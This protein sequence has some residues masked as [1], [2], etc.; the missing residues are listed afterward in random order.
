MIKYSILVPVYNVE[1]Y[2]PKCIDSIMNQNFQSED[3]EVILV[4]DGATDSSGQICDSYSDRY[5]NVTVVHQDNKGLLMARYAG[6]INSVGQYLVFIDSDDY[7]DGSFLSVIDK[8][9]DSLGPDFLVYGYLEERDTKIRRCPVTDREYEVIGKTDFIDR[10]VRTDGLNSIWNK[11][12]R[13][14]ILRENAEEVYD[15]PTNIGEDKLQT[16]FLIKYS[17]HI[18]FLGDCP[19]HYVLRD[20]SIAHHKSENDIS[21]MISVYERVRIILEDVIKSENMT[22]EK[23]KEIMRLYDSVSLSGI[24]DHVYKY[25][26]RDDLAAEN[27]CR[28]LERIKTENFKFFVEKQDL[29]SDLKLYNRVRYRLLMGNRFTS[30]I[31]LDRV[32]WITQRITGIR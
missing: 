25:D 8:H 29:I 32:L 5:S 14:D 24:L 26:K 27:K 11:V 10:F 6:V 22:E 18:A 19:Y 13:A 31:T 30:L 12:V 21:K 28:S 1:Q 3:Y 23:Q 4:D 20:S 2:L 15:F 7:I 9:I 16:A 17:E